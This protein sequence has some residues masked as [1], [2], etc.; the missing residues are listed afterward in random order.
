MTQP[1]PPPGVIHSQPKAV[2]RIAPLLLA[3]AFAL[4][5][6]PPA[7]AQMGPPPAALPSTP[8]PLIPPASRSLAPDFNLTD[9]NGK[10][11]TLSQ[12]RGHVVLLDFWAVDCGGCKI[13]IPWYVSFDHTYRA[14]GL[15]LVGIDMYGESPSMVKPF[16]AR[17]GMDYPVAIGTDTIGRQ[18]HI[19][20]M[21][22]T[23]LLDRNG[24]VALSHTG[25]VDPAKFE[26]DIRELL[27]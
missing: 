22:V 9:L 8:Y 15:Q 11:L 13:E 24:R 27:R 25:V 12:Y 23:L 17:A 4:A 20:E 1:L 2:S 10:K 5:A 18:F 26:Q 7:A 16:M 19:E 3:A 6:L 14:Q 21:P